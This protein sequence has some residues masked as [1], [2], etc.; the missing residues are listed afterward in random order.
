MKHTLQLI[1]N[2]VRYMC[3]VVLTRYFPLNALQLK[4][5]LSYFLIV[6]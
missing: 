6:N 2:P 3:L 5:K 1:L 4:M